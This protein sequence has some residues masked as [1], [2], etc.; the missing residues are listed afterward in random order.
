MSGDNWMLLVSFAKMQ[1]LTNV[2]CE[3]RT[4][5]SNLPPPKGI[6]ELTYFSLVTNCCHSCLTN[7]PRLDFRRKFPS[8]VDL[9]FT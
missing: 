4:P 2:I 8:N 7:S 9:I 3:L 6:S 5:L 1:R